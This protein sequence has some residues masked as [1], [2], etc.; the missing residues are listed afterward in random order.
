MQCEE[1]PVLHHR[2]A[3]GRQPDLLAQTCLNAFLAASGWNGSERDD[4]V[5][6]VSHGRE[7]SDE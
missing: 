3:V 7:D 5:G 6:K 4:D 2:S 1:A